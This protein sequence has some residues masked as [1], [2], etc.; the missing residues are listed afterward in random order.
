MTKAASIMLAGVV[1][2]AVAD[3]DLLTLAQLLHDAG[4]DDTAEALVVALEGKQAL[5][6]DLS[7]QDR[8]AILST[9]D[10]PQTD[11]LAELR[12][13]LL[14]EHEWRVRVGLA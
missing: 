8:E 4:F 13:T 12:E 5:V 2:V 6:V 9:L 7:I 14:L 1:G 11:A 10:D 3:K